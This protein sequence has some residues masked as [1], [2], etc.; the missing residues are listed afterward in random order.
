MGPAGSGTLTFALTYELSG[1]YR[2][3]I[4][5]LVV[6]FVVGGLLLRRVRVGEA[7]DASG[8]TACGL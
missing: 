6:F 4:V 5:V 8:T 3:A 2:V 1:S 7:I